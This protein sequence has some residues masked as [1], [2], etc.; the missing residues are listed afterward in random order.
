MTS[1]RLRY[2]EVCAGAGGLGLGLHRA[3]WTG[4]G[5]ELDTDAVATHNTHVGP[6]VRA[7][8]TVAA[9]PHEA[10]LVGGGVPCQPFS[11]AGNGEGLD[12]P[13]GQLF[14]SLLRIADESKARCVLME[15]VRGLLSKGVLAVVYQGFRAHG[16]HPVHALLNAADYGVP[17]NRVRLFILGFRDTADLARFRWPSPT[18]GAPGNLF[19]LPPWITVRKA[20]GLTGDFK[21][22]RIDGA[23]GWDGQRLLDVD[24]VSHV[25]T[26]RSNP[27]LLCQLDAPAPTI[28]AG[29]HGLPGGEPNGRPS[30]RPLA[31]LAQS[32]SRLDRPAP[33]IASG[34][35]DTGGAEPITNAR[36]RRELLNE[37]SA[38][39]LIDRTSTTVDS[40]GRASKAWHH[41]SNKTGAVRLTVRD[42]ARLQSFPDD[43]EFTG[44]ITSQFRQ[45]GNAV[46]PPF[47]Y[48]LGRA[49]RTALYG[50]EP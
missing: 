18:H 3:G 49:V 21:V 24:A 29:T 23:T 15:N 44:T 48:E 19:G 1:T 45:V 25:V 26:S 47:G 20:L 17:Q 9:A 40:T 8:V 43:V 14:R 41:E 36:V 32:I 4:T 50:D 2:V 33:T 46:P 35:A 30:R 12:D 22:G 27:E 38:A 16:F 31:A 10:D 42:C 11:T 7:D 34:G 28:V 39:G 13:R 6:C 5:M 37:L